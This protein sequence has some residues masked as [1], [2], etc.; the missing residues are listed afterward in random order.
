MIVKTVIPVS[1][2]SVLSD[3]LELKFE[4]LRFPAAHLK[5]SIEPLDPLKQ[6]NRV[7]AILKAMLCYPALR[8]QAD[9]SRGE[10]ALIG[11]GELFLDC[12]MHD[13]RN[14]FANVEIKVS[15]PFVV[16][17]ETVSARS[18]A[19]CRAHIDG[20][21]V[22]GVIAEPMPAPTQFD[23][24]S[25]RLGTKPGVG[26]LLVKLGGTRWRSTASGRSARTRRRV[27]TRSSRA[28]F[29]RG[30]SIRPCCGR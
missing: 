8:A 14:S 1:G 17:N 16:F 23:L 20:G 26:E 4:G 5:L 30:R 25:G 19:V 21:A 9:A 22:I 12:V 28:L 7:H 6:Q 3:S 15:G 18:V 2:V 27:R 29:P 13:L 10:Q 11:T 24:E